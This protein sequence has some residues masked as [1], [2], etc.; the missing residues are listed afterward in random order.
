MEVARSDS[1][2]GALSEGPIVMCH[3]VLLGDSIF[4]NA[5][6]VHGSPA[7]INQIG[8]R[9]PE[10]WRAT[11]NAVDGS[12]ILDVHRQ[13]ERL[14][15]DASHLILSV[16]GNDILG[17]IAVLGAR[18]NT[19]GEGMRRLA[20]IRDRF[21]R[22]YERLLRAMEERMLPMAV[23]TIYNPRFPD[24]GL[25]REAVAALC[26]FNDVI[27]R[28]AQRF[29]LPILDFRAICTADEDFATP[30]EPSTI[31]GA[32]IA[33]VIGDLVVHHDFTREQAVFWG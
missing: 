16:G 19:I 20:D 28:A 1:P 29:G 24:E 14:P 21:D 2:A 7:L 12:V 9:L 27:I 5:A 3:V 6:Y 4:D 25:R 17:E 23:C 30:I 11:L 31:G 18:V 26:L 32:K 8:E 13:L 10:G 33:R 15:G 22:D